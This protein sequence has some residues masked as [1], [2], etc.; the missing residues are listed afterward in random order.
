L[1]DKAQIISVVWGR[2]RNFVA[3]RA[4]DKTAK[5]TDFRSQKVVYTAV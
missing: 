2:D 1:F 3:T 4:W 5:L